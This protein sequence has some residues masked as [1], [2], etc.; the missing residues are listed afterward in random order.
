MG[1]Q[2]VQ[3]RGTLLILCERTVLPLYRSSHRA[4]WFSNLDCQ[5]LFII[6]LILFKKLGTWNSSLLHVF[7][8]Y[9]DYFTHFYYCLAS[10][11]GILLLK[12]ALQRLSKTM[13]YMTS[14]IYWS[15]ILLLDIQFVDITKNT[16]R[17]IILHNF[18]KMSA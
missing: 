10:K 8:L 7:I 17:D 15:K 14:I 13:H 4:L 3:T 5:L 2:G 18:E 1:S 6:S 12:H 9:P 11:C 16:K